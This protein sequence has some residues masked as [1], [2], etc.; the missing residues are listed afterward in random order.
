MDNIQNLCLFMH[1][2]TLVSFRVKLCLRRGFFLAVLRS[3]NSIAG[4]YTLK[5][6]GRDIFCRHFTERFNEAKAVHVSLRL[7]LLCG[8]G[9]ADKLASLRNYRF[10]LSILLAEV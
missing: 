2:V 6:S 10:Y 4:I 8:I 1:P 7:V 5:K 3:E 9:A